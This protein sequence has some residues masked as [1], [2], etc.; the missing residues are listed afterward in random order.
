MTAMIR[1]TAV[2]RMISMTTSMARMT[3]VAGMTSVT[4]VTSVLCQRFLCR[5]NN[6]QNY[7]KRTNGKQA[8]FRNACF[9]IIQKIRNR[10][11]GDFS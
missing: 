9:F 7:H 11:L 10:V 6:C 3:A 4:T 8:S 2:I 1:M 5:H